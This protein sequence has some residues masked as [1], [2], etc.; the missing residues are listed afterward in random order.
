MSW[1]WNREIQL[2]GPNNQA[3][4]E[5]FLPGCCRSFTS[6]IF[7]YIYISMLDHVSVSSLNDPNQEVQRHLAS[8]WRSNNN[9]WFPLLGFQFEAKCW[10]HRMY[11]TSRLCDGIFAAF[12]C[13]LSRRRSCV[14]CVVLQVDFVSGRKCIWNRSKTSLRFQQTK[15][16]ELELELEKE[17]ALTTCGLKPRNFSTFNL[18]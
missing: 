8:N 10:Y 17:Q 18:Y 1:R 11:Y 5:P 6:Y 7:I 13:F 14:T 15:P 9:S 12:F 4:N 16:T 3:L 2:L